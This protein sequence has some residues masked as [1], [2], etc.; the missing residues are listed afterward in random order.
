MAHPRHFIREWRKHR[1]LTQAQLAERLGIDQS[2]V[3]KIET[4][5]RRYD[6]MFLEAAALELRCSP[7]D[8]IMRDPSAPQSIWSLWDQVPEAQKPQAAEVLKAFTK[9]GTSN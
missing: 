6:Q 8:L 1:Q 3:T 7:A 5:K 4:G 9:T 2:Y